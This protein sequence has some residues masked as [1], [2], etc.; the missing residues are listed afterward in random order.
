LGDTAIDLSLETR[1]QEHI[2]QI[3]DELNAAE[4][5]HERIE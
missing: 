1:G 3:L 5:K 4:Y 2:Q